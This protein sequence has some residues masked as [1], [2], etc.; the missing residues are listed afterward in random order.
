MHRPQDKR[1]AGTVQSESRMVQ[2]NKINSD[3][4]QARVMLGTTTEAEL[5]ELAK[6]A[7]VSRRV[8]RAV[9]AGYVVSR[10]GDL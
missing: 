9:L 5:N 3:G 10:V 1:R 6:V 4:V 7:V 2:L 8:S